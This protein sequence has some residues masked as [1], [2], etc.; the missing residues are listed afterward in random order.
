[1]KKFVDALSGQNLKAKQV[2]VFGTYSGKVRPVDRAV[3]K[4]E[5]IVQEKLPNLSLIAPTLSIKVSGVSGPVVE[6]E[7]PKCVEFGRK[8]SAQKEPINNL[9]TV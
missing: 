2:A 3:R 1:M 9:I 4:L 7:L 8:I 6:G 5:K